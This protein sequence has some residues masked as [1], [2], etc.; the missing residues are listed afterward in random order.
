MLDLE[1]ELATEVVVV[2]LEVTPEVAVAVT[3]LP[4]VEALEVADTIGVA[5][6]ARQNLTP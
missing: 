2:A 3:A 4:V 6:S 1:V 5:S